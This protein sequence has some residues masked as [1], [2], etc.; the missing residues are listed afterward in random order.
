M[1]FLLEKSKNYLILHKLSSLTEIFYLPD[2]VGLVGLSIF[3]EG[4]SLIYLAIL[5]LMIY[6][7]VYKNELIN[8]N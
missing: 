4:T 6:Q 3:V 1:L 7:I 2:L 5:K 8:Q